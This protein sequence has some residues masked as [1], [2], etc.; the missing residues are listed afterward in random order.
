MPAL[1]IRGGGRGTPPIA[2]SLA[3][4]MRKYGDGAKDDDGKGERRLGL[5]IRSWALRPLLLRG[6]GAR[7]WATIWTR[8]NA[9][10]NVPA[11]TAHQPSRRRSPRWRPHPEALN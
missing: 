8:E 3:G 1:P 7:D 11:T 4:G 2:S 5:T 10:Q 6:R 9:I